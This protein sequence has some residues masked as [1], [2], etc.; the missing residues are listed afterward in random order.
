MGVR[1]YTKQSASIPRDGGGP[2]TNP[3]RSLTLLIDGTALNVPET[4]AEGY[5]KFRANV[6][7]LSQ[8]MPDRLPQ[9]EKLALIREVLREF[10]TYRGTA[11]TALRER[12]AGWRALAAALLNELL[13]NLGISASSPS[14]RP[15]LNQMGQLTTG[16]EIEAY[17]ASL[18]AFLRPG[19]AAGPLGT[20]AQLRAADRSTA[21]DNAAG[22][23]G[24]GAAIDHLGRV[25]ETGRRGFVAMFAM[26]CLDVINQRFGMDAVEDCLMAVSAFLTHSLRG[27][28]RIFHWSDSSLLA[29]LLDRPNEQIVSAELQRIASQN[30]DI[31][32]R[33]GGRIVMLR[34]PLTFELIPIERLKSADEIGRLSGTRATQGNRR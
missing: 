32:I 10:E 8:R 6:A 25:M 9:E 14:A 2:E 20:T 1:Q 16:P 21:N 15:L 3:E 18:E 22:L 11:E 7:R 28:D 4:D 5:Q 26:S 27:D 29:I 33:V 31:T 17:R 19:G 23:H 24:G 12:Q 30:R 34:I 13:A